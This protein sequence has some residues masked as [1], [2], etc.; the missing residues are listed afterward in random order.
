MPPVA[1]EPGRTFFLFFP[2]GFSWGRVIL[3]LFPGPGSTHASWN[4]PTELCSPNFETQGAIEKL[5]VSLAHASVCSLGLWEAT[6]PDLLQILAHSSTLSQGLG[7]RERE[8]RETL[9]KIGSSNQVIRETF[10]SRLKPWLSS[11]VR[12]LCQKAKVVGSIPSQSTNRNQP[13]NA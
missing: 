1:S 2:T 4:C 9:T 12:A 7:C 13:M 5:M 11:W 6:L 8:G 10:K 3:A